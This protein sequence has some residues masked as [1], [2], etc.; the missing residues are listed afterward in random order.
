MSGPRMV[1]P[2]RSFPSRESRSELMCVNDDVRLIGSNISMTYK[3]FNRDGGAKSE[4]HMPDG[5]PTSLLSLLMDALSAGNNESSLPNGPLFAGFS[6]RNWKIICRR[7]RVTLARAATEG[8][9]GRPV[10]RLLIPPDRGSLAS[11]SFLF[12]IL[13]APHCAN[14]PITII[15]I[16]GGSD[17]SGSRKIRR[18][19]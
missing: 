1:A 2:P 10:G 16:I 17:K 14:R 9:E 19:F 4:F 8:P 12:Y 5:P 13:F 18:K 6:S 3:Q 15:I 7:D 11:G